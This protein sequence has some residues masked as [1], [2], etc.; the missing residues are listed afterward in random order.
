MDINV[1]N[2]GCHIRLLYLQLCQ[3]SL[4]KV[5]SFRFW[6]QVMLHLVM[7]DCMILHF[8]A[9]NPGYVSLNLVIRDFWFL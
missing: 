5:N 3:V 4:I 8:I 6:R 7:T 2:L 9:F 1:T